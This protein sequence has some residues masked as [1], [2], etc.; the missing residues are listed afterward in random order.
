MTDAEK[1]EASIAAYEA[2]AL[3][4]LRNS[5]KEALEKRRP[6][7]DRPPLQQIRGREAG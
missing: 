5:I 6:A 4:V 1:T 3:N 2:N 7:F